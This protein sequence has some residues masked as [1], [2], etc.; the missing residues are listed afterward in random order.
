MVVKPRKPTLTLLTFFCFCFVGSALAMI[1]QAT[2]GPALP[3]C[4]LPLLPPNPISSG[5]CDSFEIL[6][7]NKWL[8]SHASRL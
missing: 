4:K 3:P 5:N 2:F 7:R 8:S 6:E 1:Q